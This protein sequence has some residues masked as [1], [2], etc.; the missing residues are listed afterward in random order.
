MQ[1]SN[2]CIGGDKHLDYK[3]ARDFEFQNVLYQE[4]CGLPAHIHII[5]LQE[6][7]AGDMSVKTNDAHNL[8]RPEFVESLWYMY[9]VTGNQTY[10]Q[11]GWQI[12]QVKALC[13]KQKWNLCIELNF[14][15]TAFSC[16]LRLFL[17]LILHYW[18]C[19]FSLILFQTYSYS[20]IWHN[21]SVVE[22][23]VRQTERKPIG[24]PG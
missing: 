7:T 15:F 13:W 2:P 19:Q 4:L 22:V 17:C 5:F 12:F 23:N 8:L 10:Q 9:Q 18:S 1:F 24:I 16:S 14:T 3:T 11:W 21:K 20:L 6:G